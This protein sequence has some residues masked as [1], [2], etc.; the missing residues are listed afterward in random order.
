VVEDADDN[1][2]VQTLNVTVGMA[3]TCGDALFSSE[4]I[5]LTLIG[6]IV[7]QYGLVV[8]RKPAIFFTA[9]VLVWTAVFF[10]LLTLIAA[11]ERYT[12]DVLVGLLVTYIVWT[13]YH[14]RLRKLGDLRVLHPIRWLEKELPPS[15]KVPTAEDEPLIM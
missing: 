7:T 15:T 10:G 12:C 13:A 5:F 3:K 2:F 4:S 11:R 1:V 9:M 6:N 8:A 14:S